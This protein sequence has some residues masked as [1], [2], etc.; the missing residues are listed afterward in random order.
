MPYALLT[1]PGP[2]EVIAGLSSGE[3]WESHDAGDSWLRL[4]FRFPGIERYLVRL[5]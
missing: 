1:G 4:D 3:V 2:G 5:P